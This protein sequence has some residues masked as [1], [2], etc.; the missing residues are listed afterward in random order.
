MAN[1]LSNTFPTTRQAVIEEV[2]SYLPVIGEFTGTTGLT[3]DAAS[4]INFQRV[5][6]SLRFAALFRVS[7]TGTD[8]GIFKYDLQ[9]GVTAALGAGVT[10][11]IPEAISP[12]GLYIGGTG[13]IAGAVFTGGSGT[14]VF[15]SNNDAGS[16]LDGDH[17]GNVAGRYRDIIFDMTVD[18]TQWTD[19]TLNTG[20]NDIEY[21]YNSNSDNTN[22]TTSFASGLD[23]VLFPNRSVGVTCSKTVQFQTEIQPTD[24]YEL[25]YTDGNGRWQSADSRFPYTRASTQVYGYDMYQTSSTTIVV[26]FAAGGFQ[27]AGAT[28]GSTGTAWSTAYTN[29]W[30]WR[31]VKHKSNV[32]VGFGPASSTA[33]GL[34]KAPSTLSLDI[35]STG[36]FSAAQPSLEFTKT[37][38]GW[39]TLAFPPL[40]HSS[41]GNPLTGAGVVPVEFRPLT[42]FDGVYNVDTSLV[43]RVLVRTNGDFQ[44][45]YYNWSGT[46]TASLNSGSNASSITYYVGL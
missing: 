15:S 41:T 28:Y 36:S 8:A 31:V 20:K 25:Q 33:A 35:S 7:G 4:Y 22:D 45:A 34:V 1:K 6:N 23:G 44:F 30:K 39:V 9:A 13:S 5:G 12:C 16:A 10:V 43:R 2:V 3:I 42:Q 38:D 24:V 21:A 18:V 17:M 14:I 40:A 46:L 27:Q 11:E 37:P 32:P 29:G 26:R 19:G